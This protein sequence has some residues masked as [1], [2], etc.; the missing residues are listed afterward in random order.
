MD[1]VNV[2]TMVNLTGGS[3]DDLAGTITDF[4]Q[5]FPGR[6]VSM[7]EPSWTRAS[8]TGYAAWQ[9]DEIGR[10]RRRAPWA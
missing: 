9:A 5:A 8:E 3:G 1:A 7:T 10:P 4:D 2:R 6:F